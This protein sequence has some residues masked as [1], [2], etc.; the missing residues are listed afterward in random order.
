MGQH[1]TVARRYLGRWQRHPSCAWGSCLGTARACHGLRIA[2]AHPRHGHGTA[3]KYSMALAQ[4]W[5]GQGTPWRQH[6]HSM[7]TTWPWT[8]PRHGPCTGMAWHGPGMTLAWCG[9]WH[10]HGTATS[11]R[12]HGMATAWPQNG[13]STA[14]A[15]HD[16][17]LAW[18]WHGTARLLLPRVPHPAATSAGISFCS[19]ACTQGRRFPLGRR[20]WGHPVPPSAFHNQGDSSTF[21]TGKSVDAHNEIRI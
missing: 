11:W 5:H 9:P 17:S 4:P 1:G 14:M 6:S 2:M 3:W 20:S 21:L 7:S 15:Q 12:S 10:G 13:D 19:Q 8:W 16:H 18:P